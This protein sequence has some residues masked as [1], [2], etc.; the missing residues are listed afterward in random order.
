MIQQLQE[1]LPYESAPGHLIY[2]NDSQPTQSQALGQLR[3]P[4]IFSNRVTEAIA[5]GI[6][7]LTA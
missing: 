4:A 3:W 1:M 2:D 6:C 5:T 7:G